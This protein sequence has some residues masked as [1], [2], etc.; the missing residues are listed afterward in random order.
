MPLTALHGNER[1]YDDEVGAAYSPGVPWQVYV[2]AFGP[3]SADCKCALP[4]N[5]ETSAGR[6]AP[7][8]PP[9]CT[10][11]AARKSRS[12]SAGHPP[13]ATPR[14]LFGKS[15]W[16]TDH[17]KSVRSKRAIQSSLAGD[18]SCRPLKRNP[19]YGFV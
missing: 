9:R 18:W 13:R 14:D 2:S 6:S 12:A 10:G 8:C 1:V 7:E 15:G 16:I 4:G 17:S 3:Y 11:A 5:H 19:I